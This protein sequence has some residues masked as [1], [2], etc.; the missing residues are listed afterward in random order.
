MFSINAFST[1]ST[2]DSAKDAQT[3][4][5]SSNAKDTKTIQ[6]NSA[7]GEA[8]EI[9]SYSAES[10]FFFKEVLISNTNKSHIAGQTMQFSDEGLKKP[11]TWSKC[12]AN[13]FQTRIGPNYHKNKGKAPSLQS[14]YDVAGVDFFKCNT[15]IDNIS[16]RIRFS[17]EWTLN[18]PTHSFVP[19]IYVLNVQ[20]CRYL[21]F[22]DYPMY[23]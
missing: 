17:D 16:S 9:P 18:M 7:A 13:S 6:S 23:F 2:Y 22:C 5:T 8:S 10:N 1:T 15:R 21:P 20:V 3:A 12:D 19:P 14:F 4:R 11:N